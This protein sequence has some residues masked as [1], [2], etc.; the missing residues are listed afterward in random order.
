MKFEK[1]FFIVIISLL[2]IV[3][4][5][6]FIK[7]YNT[8]KKTYEVTQM[9]FSSLSILNNEIDLND[10]KRTYNLTIECTSLKD[11]NTQII[12]Y[13]L[14]KFATD[15]NISTTTKVYDDNQVLLDNYDHITAINSVLSLT[16]K[17]NQYEQIF[18]I[19][20]TCK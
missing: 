14:Q 18:I 6:V 10:N 13:N 3:L 16:D 19:N 2:I 17:N 12:S 7:R 1:K 20:A 15:Y 4:L 11:E 8:Y 5:I 9:P